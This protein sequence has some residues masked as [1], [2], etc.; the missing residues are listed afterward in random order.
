M[1]CCVDHGC[2]VQA[3]CRAI[4]RP[5]RAGTVALTCR[6]AGVHPHYVRPCCSLRRRTHL[7]PTRGLTIKSKRWKSSDWI[8]LVCGPPPPA[9]V[10]AGRIA[11]CLRDASATTSA[12]PGAGLVLGLGSGSATGGAAAADGVECP[13][14]AGMD[15]AWSP[16][17]GLSSK[18]HEGPCLCIGLS[19]ISS[20]ALFL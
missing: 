8:W 6:G 18:W 13:C 7:F 20:A 9:G 12:P 10:V 19:P 5:K 2:T 11:T 4:L 16:W 17:S 14:T 1:R 3:N 15:D